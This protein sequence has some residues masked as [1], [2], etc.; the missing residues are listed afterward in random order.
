MYD[1]EY[2]YVLAISQAGTLSKAAIQLG[3]SQ[4]A[5]SRFLQ[6]EEAAV[7]TKL[8][9]KIDARMVLTYAG[10]YYVENVKQILALQNQMLTTIQD[11]AKADKG[12]VRIGVPSI[13]RPYTIFSV[14]PKFKQL[15]P[16]VDIVL[17]ENDSN[18]LEEMLENLSLDIIAVNTTRSKDEFVFEKIADEEYVLA[19]HSSS[20]L[21]QEAAKKK[22]FKYPVIT[23]QQLEGQS[24][25]ILDAGH[26]IRQ[27]TDS[28][29]EDNRIRYTVSM[30]ARTL[31]SALE[32]VAS[33][34]GCTFTPEVLLAYIRGSKNIRYLSLD[35]PNTQYEFGL[36]TRKGAYL[37]PSM[38][39]FIQIF[40][41]NYQKET[42]GYYHE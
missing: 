18:T 6:R 22:D 28:I 37:P 35:A 4:P 10:E 36:F 34:L 19:V 25:V 16:S 33:N 12:R 5:L 11:I 40:K 1:R 39:D 27:F 41:E 31:D 30:Q 7:G 24:M 14:I 17:N 32:A 9:Q 42:Q 13:R 26:R 15:Y 3:V 20:P 38:K 2:E 23:M 8:F 21:L 29:L